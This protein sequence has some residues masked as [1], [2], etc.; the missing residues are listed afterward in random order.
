[1]LTCSNPSMIIQNIKEGTPVT[2]EYNLLN[3]GTVQYALKAN[4]SCGCSVPT[5][6]K[7]TIDP[8]EELI[9]KVVFDSLGK[10][11]VSEKNIYVNYHDDKQLIANR[12]TLKFTVVVHK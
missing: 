12:L 5:L 11:G 8:G 4:A 2:I 3:Q 7:K 10:T 9:M 1:M 6:P